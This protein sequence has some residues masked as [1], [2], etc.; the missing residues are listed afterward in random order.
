VGVG[1]E[2]VA[3]TGGATVEQTP[4]CV[5]AAPPGIA[6]LP[7]APVDTPAPRDERY[8]PQ[9]GFRVDD[10][11]IGDYVDRRGG[12]AAFGYPISRT[13]VFQGFVVQ[14]FQRRVVQLDPDGHARLLNLLDADLLP[15]TSFNFSRI[16]ARDPALAAAAPSIDAVRRGAPDSHAGIPV[17]FY[18]AFLATVPSAAAFPTGGDARLVPGFALE[19]WGVPTSRP[20][21]DPNNRGVV[22][23]RWQR[24]V[25][26]YDAATGR[27]QGVLLADYLKSV[28]TGTNLPADLASEARDSPFYRQY[29]PSVAG[30]VRDP[31]RLR[32]T[33]LTN[34][35][36]PQ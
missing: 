21:F 23:L 35:F 4:P 31:V 33:D 8:Y 26:Q 17:R 1:D 22:Y 19:M 15:Y 20:A 7:W 18:Q 13:F 36:A 9:T 30:W 29:D 11:T 12:V 34:A 28:L 16:P 6:V 3:D 32:L 27:T 2:P 25:M 5:I 14:F 10:D 24:G